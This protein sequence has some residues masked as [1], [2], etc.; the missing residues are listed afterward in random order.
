MAHLSD[1]LIRAA[2][3]LDQGIDPFHPDWLED[4]KVTHEEATCITSQMAVALR[5]YMAFA[6]ATKGSLQSP[7]EATLEQVN[8]QIIDKADAAGIP[9]EKLMQKYLSEAG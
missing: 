2:D 5:V 7:P 8:S 3:T 9:V 4:N 1:L 6:E